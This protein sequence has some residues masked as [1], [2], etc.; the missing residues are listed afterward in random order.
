MTDE[1]FSENVEKGS[2]NLIEAFRRFRYGLYHISRSV[3][4]W[5]DHHPLLKWVIL[6]LL[7]TGTGIVAVE[8]ISKLHSYFF[9]AIVPI[10]RDA[11]VSVFPAPIGF[12]LWLF[13]VLFILYVLASYFRF[14]AL[15]QRID[16][17]EERVEKKT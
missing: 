10:Q 14:V 5:F 3:T 6:A 11:T 2:D 12:T 4:I 9:G 1:E 13:S 7:S 8:I 17:L 16:E 15:R